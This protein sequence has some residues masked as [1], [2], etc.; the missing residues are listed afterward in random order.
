MYVLFQVPDGVRH[1]TGDAELVQWR[2]LVGV[3]LGSAEGGEVLVLFAWYC[4]WPFQV[5]LNLLDKES[6]VVSVP[7]GAE[8]RLAVGSQKCFVTFLQRLLGCVAE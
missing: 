3:N 5:L 8:I 1:L 6:E 7:P 4:G 2:M